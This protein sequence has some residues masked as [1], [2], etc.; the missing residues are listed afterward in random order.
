MTLYSPAFRKSNHRG[1]Q[2]ARE[3]ALE[4]FG[5]DID[6]Y[7]F[8]E[9]AGALVAELKSRKSGAGFVQLEHWLGDNNLLFLWRDRQDPMVCMGWET[10]ALILQRLK[11]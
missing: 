4:A 6:I 10:W 1:S 8:G 9:D 2:F 5:H 3:A 7:P 11:S